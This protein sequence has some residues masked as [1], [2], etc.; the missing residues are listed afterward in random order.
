MNDLNLFKLR[1]WVREATEK[2][3]RVLVV[4]VNHGQLEELPK[5]KVILWAGVDHNNG[6]RRLT[7]LPSGVRLVLRTRFTD[8]MK[9]RLRALIPPDV[10]YVTRKLNIG[11]LRQIFD[12]RAHAV[13]RMTRF[14]APARKPGALFEWV[15][16]RWDP[17]AS[18][19]NRTI[20]TQRLFL[21]AAR[22]GVTGTRSAIYGAL[23]RL[24][25]GQVPPA[26]VLPAPPA[27]PPVPRPLL[28]LPEPA[29]PDP[30][31]SNG[32]PPTRPPCEQSEP[33]PAPAPA[34]KAGRL[35]KLIRDLRETLV[36]LALWGEEL[37]AEVEMLEA[38]KRRLAGELADP[39]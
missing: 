18:R 2:E 11:Q 3:G 33:G 10:R 39:V 20:E 35:R 16:T 4:G 7:A 25:A 12:D 22:E 17:K 27:P 15:R 24:E 1:E 28:P 34:A 6:Q 14:V 19:L 23:R 21:L 9:D 36:V 5:S 8:G 38:R 26:F 29:P 37:E 30:P 31:P 13:A 32:A